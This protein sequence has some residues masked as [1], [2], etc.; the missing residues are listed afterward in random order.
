MIFQ[1]LNEANTVER[2]FFAQG[3]DPERT[4]RFHCVPNRVNIKLF[5][6]LINTMLPIHI[7]QGGMLHQIIARLVKM[8]GETE[9]YTVKGSV[10]M[11]PGI[12]LKQQFSGTGYNE[13]VRLFP[14]FSSRMYFIEAT[15]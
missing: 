5:G 1:E 14:D 2:R 7:K 13:N 12:G 9:D 3:L 6:S 11:G 8:G 10:L 15:D 4:Y